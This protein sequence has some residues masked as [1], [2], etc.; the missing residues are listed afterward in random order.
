MQL[1]VYLTRDCLIGV[2]ITYIDNSG[3]GYAVMI[4][5]ELYTLPI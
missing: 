4:I 3:I 2:Y 5:L 1:R